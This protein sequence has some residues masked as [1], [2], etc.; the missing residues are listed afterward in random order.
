MIGMFLARVIFTVTAVTTAGVMVVS[1]HNGCDL[2]HA[3]A[4]ATLTAIVCA[5]A[6]TLVLPLLARSL[7]PQPKSPPTP[8]AD[9]GEGKLASAAVTARAQA[10]VVAAEEPSRAA[11]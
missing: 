3:L 10:A 4:R 7:K 1:M 5:T 9:S 6:G 2:W 11:A 8:A